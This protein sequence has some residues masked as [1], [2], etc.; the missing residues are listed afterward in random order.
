M[1]PNLRQR[2]INESYKLFISKGIKHT[3][4]SD[5]AIAVN[6]SKGAVLHYFPS[7]NQLVNTV[8]ENCF[9]PSSALSPEMELLADKE[10]SEFI[11]NYKNPI[12]RAIHNFPDKQDRIGLLHYM[13]FISSANEYMSEFSQKYQNLLAEEQRF[14]YNVISKTIAKHN[15]IVNDIQTFSQQT[16]EMSIGNTFLQLISS[17]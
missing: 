17:K 10:W 15:L 3:S 11:Q 7:K 5:I 4:F 14:L 6:K 13:Q 16:F 1:D 2:I 8:I 9:F 12:E